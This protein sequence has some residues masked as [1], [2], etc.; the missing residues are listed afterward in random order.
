MTTILDLA[1]NWLRA[2]VVDGVASSGIN[3]PSKTDGL[4]V[5]DEISSEIVG[6]IIGFSSWAELSPVIPPGALDGYLAKVYSDSGT[7]TDPV[8]GGTVAN[9]GI[10]RFHAA[11]VTGW[12]RI[13][14]LSSIDI[15]SAVAIIPLGTLSTSDN[16][17]Y[18]CSAPA[19]VGSL[20]TTQVYSFKMP[21][22]ANAG[23]ATLNVGSIG[24]KS[25]VDKGGNAVT[26]GALGASETHLLAYDGTKFVCI[27][28]R[29]YIAS[30]SSVIALGATTNTGGTTYSIASA[31]TGL[32]ALASGQFFAVQFD[33]ANT[34]A[35]T[36]QIG[37]LAS[38][39]VV[40]KAGVAMQANMVG[41]SETH[42]LYYDGSH[43]ISLERAKT[44]LVFDAN[45]Y[46]VVNFYH[47]GV[48][49]AKISTTANNELSFQS[50]VSGVMQEVARF[51]SGTG[52]FRSFFGFAHGT[53]AGAAATVYDSLNPQPFAPNDPDAVFSQF[54]KSAAALYEYMDELFP[55]SLA[56]ATKPYFLNNGDHFR[57]IYVKVSNPT[58]DCTFVPLGCPAGGIEIKSDGSHGFILYAGLGND[59]EGYDASPAA[60]H[61]TF[62]A[63]SKVRVNSW[64]SGKIEV[65]QLTGS[66]PTTSTSAEAARGKHIVIAGQSNAVKILTG[67][68]LAGLQYGLAAQTYDGYSPFN[69]AVSD[70]VWYTQAAIGSSALLIGNQ[71]ASQPTNYW[72]DA[73][74]TGGGTAGPN[75][76]ALIAAVQAA[77]LAGQPAP[78]AIVWCQGEQDVS[79]VGTTNGA[80]ITTS[81]ATYKAALGA[82][83]AY[84]RAALSL[85]NLPFIIVPLGANDTLANESKTSAIREAM[86]SYIGGDAHAYQGPEHY[87]LPRPVGNVH[88]NFQGYGLLGLRLAGVLANVVWSQ[89]NDVGPTVLAVDAPTISGTNTKIKVHTSPSSS[90][91]YDSFGMSGFYVVPSGM[92]AYDAAQAGM[93]ISTANGLII[94]H[95]FNS[96]SGQHEFTLTFPTPA[97]SGTPYDVGY[98]YGAGAKLSQSGRIIAETA[99]GLPLRCY[100]P[101]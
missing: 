1:R 22:A 48:L 69:T 70:S 77:I 29:N 8:V 6:G 92:N 57:G 53:T 88:H 39:A 40:D 14:D 23:A 56:S 12:E 99:T 9:S 87:D 101:L 80:G 91:N 61:L 17:A 75:T 55:Y 93:L 96:G 58:I 20:V 43:F 95:F 49:S 51:D 25:I 10:Y 71:A 82:M 78:A 37:A 36:L 54:S 5:F 89:S 47:S 98:F 64:I 50:T 62:A 59:F 42:L 16:L 15:P 84:I 85:P 100:T 76:L 74:N 45:V 13:A 65:T 66:A 86:L 33:A 63:G 27:T 90:L 21:A 18:T 60:T 68:G 97:W 94:T 31:P 11:S 35:M 79:A 52:F 67:G 32:T 81:F 26:A 24:A 72:W 19:G 3:D 73:T 41:A 30:A 2:Y 7:H 28:M 38:K 44:L 83:I 46:D 34:G 4:A